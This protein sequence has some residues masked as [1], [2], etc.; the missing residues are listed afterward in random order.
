MSFSSSHLNDGSNLNLEI[1]KDIYRI[2]VRESYAEFNQHPHI[3]KALVNQ[4]QFINYISLLHPQDAK[5]FSEEEEKKI[6]ALVKGKLVGELICLQNDGI[7]PAS[8]IWKVHVLVADLERGAPILKGLLKKKLDVAEFSSDLHDI[9]RAA[10]DQPVSQAAEPPASIEE[11][12]ENGSDLDERIRREEF[13]LE[14]R[15][16]PTLNDRLLDEAIFRSLQEETKQE[17]KHQTNSVTPSTPQE[18]KRISLPLANQNQHQPKPEPADEVNAEEAA[19][20]R[21]AMELSLQTPQAQPPVA[22]AS[23]ATEAK[24]NSVTTN[25]SSTSSTPSVVQPN[26]V[27]SSIV[28][29]SL[30]S[31]PADN[32]VTNADYE[33]IFSKLE[34][35]W[36]NTKMDYKKRGHCTLWL[37]RK[38]FNE[39]DA[40][41]KLFKAGKIPV[42]EKIK[43]LFGAVMVLSQQAEEGHQKQKATLQNNSYFYLAARH[44]FIAECIKRVPNLIKDVDNC[45]E[46]YKNIQRDSSARKQGKLKFS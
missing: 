11:D 1:V 42:V 7:F 40:L 3:F 32:T 37:R 46:L 27:S 21:R 41:I 18:H 31:P 25:K 13:A 20:L 28:R 10:Q 8:E 29:H 30:F 23:I 2:I 4:T 33:K 34:T 9:V 5:S 24:T 38:E 39:I 19:M 44:V 22:A 35:A 45:E 36:A 12:R 17:Q 26:P 16:G 14:Q 15:Q 6:H 43:T